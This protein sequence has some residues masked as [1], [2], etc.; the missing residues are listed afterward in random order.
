[1]I[2]HRELILYTANTFRGK[3]IPKENPVYWPENYANFA[4]DWTVI[5]LRDLFWCD[6]SSLPN[7]TG[8]NLGIV[9]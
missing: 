6:L 4:Q 5:S 8:Y 9:G 3:I 2:R 7:V 1:M